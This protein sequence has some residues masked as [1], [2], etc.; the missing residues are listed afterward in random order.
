M[1]GGPALADDAPP[2]AATAHLQ[3]AGDHARLSFDL[4]APVAGRARE[5]ADPD[6]IV[7]DMP[8]VD[9]RLSASVGRVT[10]A[11]PTRSSRRSGS[12]CSGPASRAW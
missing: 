4:S 6:R 9:F 2:V 12:A 1:L 5:I 3:D 8:E 10:A 7:L 11:R